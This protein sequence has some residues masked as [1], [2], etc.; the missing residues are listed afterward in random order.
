MSERTA[1][2]DAAQIPELSSSGTV[3]SKATRMAGAFK[4]QVDV[5]LTST[6]GGDVYVWLVV[7]G[8]A[9]DR[10]ADAPKLNSAV[11][12]VTLEVPAGKKADL[13]AEA[14][15]QEATIAWVGK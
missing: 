11:K 14:D 3:G 15:G 10:P 2:G 1:D 6:R 7:E 9:T 13:W 8:K 4:Q 5:T 12:S